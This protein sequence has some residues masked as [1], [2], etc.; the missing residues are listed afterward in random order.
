MKSAS[1]NDK[2]YYGEKALRRRKFVTRGLLSTSIFLLLV[3][4]ISLSLAM[5]QARIFSTVHY[6]ADT[7]YISNLSSELYKLMISAYEIKSENYSQGKDD[8]AL[9]LDVLYAVLS[10][11]SNDLS[12]Q[13]ELKEYIPDAENV[14]SELKSFTIYWSD[15]LDNVQNDKE[16]KVVSETILNDAQ[17]LRLKINTTIAKF[18][19]SYN[20]QE[21]EQK[22]SQGKLAILFI[23]SFF[24]L[25]IGVVLFIWRLIKN[26][27]VTEAMAD[28]LREANY[29]LEERVK[30]RTLALQHMASTDE[31]TGIYNRRAFMEKA[32]SLIV[33]CNTLD[34]KYG[35]LMLDIDNFKSVNDHYG[36]LV[37]DGVIKSVGASMRSVFLES[38]IFG[39]IGGEEFAA[40]LPLGRKPDLLEIAEEIRSLIEE[41][42]IIIND[43]LKI[44]IT[45][46]IGI[47]YPEHPYETLTQLLS[48][49]DVA[50]YRAKR[51]GRNKVCQFNDGSN[52]PHSQC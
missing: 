11:D 26:H 29:T 21:V 39:R 23:F 27:Q 44:S 18:N 46:S 47:T 28:T 33:K 32:D 31:L 24:I 9:R 10:T 34:L 19:Q 50:L 20:Q 52:D 17:P 25:L 3:A 41:N 12:Y 51:T 49:A 42:I 37:G 40:I 13:T 48:N 1:N 30:E 36:H 43:E 15:L 5:K 14:F 6:Y 7:W 45:V 22:I 16:L 2:T 35:L 4:V 38:G 8:I